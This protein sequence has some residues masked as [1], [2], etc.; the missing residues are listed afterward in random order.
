MTGD[1]QSGTTTLPAPPA[2]PATICNSP[3]GTL[4]SQYPL[5]STSQQLPFSKP[6]ELSYQMFAAFPRREGDT[7]LS[8]FIAVLTSR[9]EECYEDVSAA[10]DCPQNPCWGFCALL[11]H[12][13]C[14]QWPS[15]PL[16]RGQKYRCWAPARN[17][18]LAPQGRS[19]AGGG[20]SSN[21]VVG[22]WWWQ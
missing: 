20:S 6:W 19:G 18:E 17:P 22:R 1:A 21:T 11:Q 15:T 9:P 14:P 4:S 2:L 10:S 7:R 13:C 16:R 8:E 5:R 12:S 3:Q